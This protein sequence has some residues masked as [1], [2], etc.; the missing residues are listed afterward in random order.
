LDSLVDQSAIKQSLSAT[1]PVSLPPEMTQVLDGFWVRYDRKW[2]LSCRMTGLTAATK[3]RVAR[4]VS[5]LEVNRL[6][7]LVQLYQ[8]FSGRFCQH[9]SS[10]THDT[11]DPHIVHLVYILEQTH[12][13]EVGL[14]PTCQEQI[15][16]PL[17][18]LYDSLI[19][20]IN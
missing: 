9:T 20:R 6:Q 17:G 12:Q 7:A 19:E 15:V 4:V 14:K 5:Y 13:A 16:F 2:I 18:I 8:V 11:V 3:R 10:I 1:I